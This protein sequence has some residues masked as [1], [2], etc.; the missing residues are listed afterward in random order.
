MSE[1][2]LDRIGQQADVKGPCM[3][4]QSTDGGDIVGLGPT[5][6]VRQGWILS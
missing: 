1:V 3:V 5:S 6:L 2:S 4:D